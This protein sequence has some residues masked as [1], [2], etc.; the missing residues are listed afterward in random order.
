MSLRL[1]VLASGQG[2]LLEAI[3]AHDVPISLVIA[4]R[5]CAALEVATHAGIQTLLL[6][7][8]FNAR[9][10]RTAYTDMILEIFRRYRI[11]LIAMAGFMTA[12]SPALFEPHAYMLRV[13]NIHPSLLPSFKGKNAV[14]DA[15]AHGVKVTGCTIHWATSD[16]DGGPILVQE[17]VRV[18]PGD[19]TE[20]LHARIKEVE[21][22]LYPR[23]LREIVV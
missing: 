4:D 23:F 17:P 12:F 18:L 14:A 21:R 9:F 3:I 8:H 19:T 6:P 13:L 11:E 2:S 10:D 16:V 1:A 20:S 5:P 7:R 15:L 22:T